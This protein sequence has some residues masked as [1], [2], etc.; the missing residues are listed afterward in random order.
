MSG[1]G[2][3]FKKFKPTIRGKRCFLLFPVQGSE[4]KGLVSVEVKKKKGQVIDI[5]R[6]SISSLG[7]SVADWSCLRGGLAYL[8]DP[9]GAG[10]GGDTSSYGGL[11]I[12]RLD[13]WELGHTSWHRQRRRRN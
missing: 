6:S 4:R 7:M 10:C 12:R 11:D 2:I 5:D 13:L 9:D 1:G 8:D 3:T